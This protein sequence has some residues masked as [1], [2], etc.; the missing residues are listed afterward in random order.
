MKQAFRMKRTIAAFTWL[1]ACLALAGRAQACE[2]PVSV[3]LNE[4]RGSFP[5]I[6]AEQ[7]AAIITNAAADLATARGPV[8]IIGTLGQSAAVDAL[9]RSGKI[10]ATDLAGEWEAFRQIVVDAPLPGITRA[11]VIVGSGRR[12]AVFGTYDLSEKIGVS[13]LYWF[14]DVPTE[15]KASVY[16]T[17]G[18]RRDQPQVRYRGF[19]INDESPGLATWARQKFGGFNA[20]MYAHVFELLQRMKGNYLRPAMWKPAAFNDDDPQNMILADQMGVVTGTSHHEPMTRAHAEW[21]RNK[22]HGITGGA[23]DYTKNA[24]NLQ[25]FWRGGIERMMSK[26]N[27]QGFDSV[28]T[29]GMRGEGDAP[30]A[31]GTATELLQRTSG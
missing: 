23:W 8:V 11:L 25:K 2:T 20:G 4:M 30:M 27:G 19:L 7:P 6:R 9:V 24:A 17:A 22:D 14:D 3:C 26:G 13:P 12:G 16:I 28:V 29:V 15:H 18:N 31:E 1:V 10:K 5:L 21:D